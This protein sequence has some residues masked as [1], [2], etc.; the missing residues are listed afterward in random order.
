MDWECDFCNKPESEVGELL[1][2]RTPLGRDYQICQECIDK[3]NLKK[4][5][6]IDN[7]Y[8]KEVIK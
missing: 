3:H 6:D 2:G 1:T 8:K 4:I 5:S 7:Y